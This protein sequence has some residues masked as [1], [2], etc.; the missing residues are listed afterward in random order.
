MP[1]SALRGFRAVRTVGTPVVVAAAI[2]LLS[3]SSNTA[4]SSDPEC[5]DS[6][7]AEN[8][9]CIAFEGATKCQRL[10]TSN[11][12]PSSSCPFNYTCSQVDGIATP[13]CVLTTAKVGDKPI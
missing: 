3:F 1:F 4:C 12:D 2:M 10:C 9:K 13:I 7:C 6:K 11:A 5:V 8:N